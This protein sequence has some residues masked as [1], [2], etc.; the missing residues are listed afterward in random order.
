MLRFKQ[1]REGIL[2]VLWEWSLT[3]LGEAT[4]LI[5]T[6]LMNNAITASKALPWFSPVRLW[7]LSDRQRVLVLVWEACPQPP[8]PTGIDLSAENGRGPLLVETS[9]E[10]FHPAAP[11]VLPAVTAGPPQVLA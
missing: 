7:L 4:E 5:V 2:N 6:E 1:E 10:S 9:P 11:V 3:R 8:Q